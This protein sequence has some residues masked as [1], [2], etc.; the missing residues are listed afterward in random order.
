MNNEWLKDL[1]RKYSTKGILLDTNLLL[2]LLIGGVDRQRVGKFKRTADFGEDTFDVLVEFLQAFEKKVTTPH[3]LT[4]VSNLASSLYGDDR[5]LF[6]HAFRT[7]V[8]NSQEVSI[9][10]AEAVIDENLAAFGL[11]DT[12]ILSEAAGKYLLITTD[13]ALKSMFES[14]GGDALGIGYL[15]ERRWGF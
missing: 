10:S 5:K 6:F 13:L 8:M 15:L 1:Q 7:F 12:I 2:V 4:E 3:V 14:T 9:P 11:T